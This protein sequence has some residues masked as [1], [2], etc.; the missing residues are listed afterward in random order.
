[1][2]L[3]DRDEIEAWNL[4]DGP[5]GVSRVAIILEDIEVDP[6]VRWLKL[7]DGLKT[8]LK[9]YSVL[10]PISGQSGFPAWWTS[11]STSSV[12]KPLTSGK[13]SDFTPRWWASNPRPLHLPILGRC[14][15][16]GW[17]K[18]QLMTPRVSAV[19][20]SSRTSNQPPSTGGVTTD[21][22]AEHSGRGPP[23]DDPSTAGTRGFDHRGERGDRVGEIHRVS[24]PGR[25]SLVA[26]QCA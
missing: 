12:L 13:P 15:S 16:R 4:R 1:M 11:S 7:P 24:H 3:R 22:P 21:P 19:S 10:A 17:T 23:S 20:C 8:R 14:S 26:G 9:V 2:E 6:G 5:S 18:P 25:R